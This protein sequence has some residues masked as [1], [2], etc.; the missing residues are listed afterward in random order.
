MRCLAS[1]IGESIR[2]PIPTPNVPVHGSL[3]A[4][5]LSADDRLAILDLVHRFDHAINQLD[6]AAAGAMFTA[7]GALHTP[8]GAMQGREAIVAYFKAVEHMAKGNRH[9]TSNV[10]ID[11]VDPAPTASKT[12]RAYSYRLLV[13]ASAPTALVA[14][15]TIEDELTL[16]NGHWRF[17]SRKF[18]MDA[19]A[20]APP[21]PPQ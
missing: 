5:A 1:R 8:K 12:A 7:Q 6:Q 19:P 18:L 21:L 11:E 16:E 20:A 4:H 10:V 2:P 13:K 3:Q 15:G 17:A 9:L 14:S